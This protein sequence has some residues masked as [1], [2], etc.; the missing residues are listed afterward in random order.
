MHVDLITARNTALAYS[1]YPHPSS[2]VMGLLFP[3][4]VGLPKYQPNTSFAV[5]LQAAQN[6]TMTSATGHLSP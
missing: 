2:W 1:E 6:D 4:I 3:Q 5:E